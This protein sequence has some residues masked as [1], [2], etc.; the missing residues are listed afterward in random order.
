[1]IEAQP[2]PYLSEI[3]ERHAKGRKDSDVVINSIMMV[4]AHMKGTTSSKIADLTRA[5]L[6]A[7]NDEGYLRVIAD[8]MP[9]GF[10][11]AENPRLVVSNIAHGPEHD[12][13]R[14]KDKVDMVVFCYIAHEP[15]NLES[16][17]TTNDQQS[18]LSDDISWHE[19]LVRSG[20]KLTVNIISTKIDE[21]DEDLELPL[22]LL[23][24]EPYTVIKLH[25]GPWNG[26]WHALQDF[27]F[28]S[29]RDAISPK[30]LTPA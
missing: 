22:Q 10:R 9:D 2:S 15:D 18:P 19:S 29:H 12:F 6:M 11:L 16:G 8:N 1:M 14:H 28:L 4:G 17:I 21:G 27:Q 23:H 30:K 7:N 24:R 13:L 25:H 3:F 5:T 26:A 20:A